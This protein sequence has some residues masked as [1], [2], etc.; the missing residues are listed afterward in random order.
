MAKRGCVGVFVCVG[1]WERDSV[2]MVSTLCVEEVSAVCL[3][4]F[5]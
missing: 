5:G 3:S 2:F 1:C 4:R